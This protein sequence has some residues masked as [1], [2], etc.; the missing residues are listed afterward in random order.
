MVLV[1]RSLYEFTPATSRIP[2]VFSK[3]AAIK[4]EKDARLHN[5]G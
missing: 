2:V 3:N 5:K 4:Q 1:F